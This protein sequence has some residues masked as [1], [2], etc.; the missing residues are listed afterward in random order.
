MMFNNLIESSS[1]VREYK[2]RGS[3]VL[4]TAVIYGVLFIAS[5]VVAIYAYDARL[6]K[7]S[8]EFV[9][10]LPPQEIVPEQVPAVVQPLERPR[11]TTEKDLRIPE[12]KVAMA[13]VNQPEVVPEKVSATPNTNLPRPPG[14]YR[15]SDHDRNVLIG[16]GGS[17]T[18]LDSGRQVD[19][20]KRVVEIPDIQPPPELPKQPKIVSKGPIT[21][22]ATY[23]PKPAYSEI[24]KRLRI[25]GVVRVQVLVGLDGR[26]ESATVLNG[27]PYL[28]AEAQKAAMQARFSP[29]TLNDQPVKVSGVIIYNFQLQ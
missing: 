7:Q 16:G 9:T 1:H 29:T 2:R 12:R 20:P 25:E 22:N 23:L 11:A 17:G 24:A 13:D 10:L 6:E 4:F 28:R 27:S 15:I 14:P 26:V 21:G 19:Q 8:L 5:G 3:F 18:S